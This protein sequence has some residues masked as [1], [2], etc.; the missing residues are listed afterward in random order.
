[1]R[2]FWRSLK[3]RSCN[4]PINSPLLLEKATSLALALGEDCFTATTGFIDRW[5]KQ[6]GIVMKKVSSGEASS[7]AEDTRPWLDV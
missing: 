7:V 3:A 6:H 5:K 2:P 1:M 4:I